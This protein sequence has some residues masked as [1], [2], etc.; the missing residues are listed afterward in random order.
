MSSRV[1]SVE[2]SRDRYARTAEFHA[3]SKT[4]KT[5]NFCTMVKSTNPD[6]FRLLS[7]VHDQYAPS[8]LG[9]IVVRMFDVASVLEP[10]L[11]AL[12]QRTLAMGVSN[13]IEN[14]FVNDS[15]ITIEPGLEHLYYEPKIAKFETPGFSVK[16]ECTI[17][18]SY[19]EVD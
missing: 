18:F 11:T 8:N 7:R 6:E 19:T 1:L 3:G 15:L 5:P 16:S 14:K 4:I 13:S 12:G 17:K 10:H 2:T 9:S